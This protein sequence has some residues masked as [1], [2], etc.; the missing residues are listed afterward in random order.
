VQQNLSA[1]DRRE[2]L[3]GF[4]VVVGGARGVLAAEGGGHAPRVEGLERLLALTII[5]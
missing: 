4:R 2:H 1:P 3:R 5:T